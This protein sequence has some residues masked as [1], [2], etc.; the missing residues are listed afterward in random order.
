MNK[1][2]SIR[3][4]N[5]IRK[6]TANGHSESKLR[7][8]LTATDL[9]FLGI[10]AIVGAG[11]FILTGVA[12]A[13]KAGP[14][15]V[16]S[17]VLAGL[18][19]SFAAFAYAEL[20]STVGGAGSAYSYGYVTLGEF[21]AWIIGWDLILEYSVSVCAVAIGWS[22]YV[23]NVLEVLG[24]HLPAALIKGPGEG[25]ILNLPAIFIILFLCGIQALGVKHSARFNGIIVLM[26]L[27]AIGIFIAV[28][29][30]DFNLE[31]WSPFAPF[32]WSGI[33]GGAALVFFAYIGFDAVSTAA[34]ETIKPQR[35]LSIGILGSLMIC[36][37]LY[38][39][40]SG[41]L[42]G[43]TSYSLLNVKSPVSEAILHLGHAVA[44]G[45]IAVGAI[46]GLT[47]V[48][49]IFIYGFTRIFYAI[50]QDGLL[51]SFFS[52]IHPKT[53]VPHR[54]IGF[55]AL[56][57]S[58]IAGLFSI[59]EVAE[60]VNIG[61]LAAFVIVCVGVIVLR[62]RAPT[63]HRPFK[64]PLF[65]F[66]PIMGIILCGYLMLSLPAITW[67]RFV[68]WWIIGLL[69]YFTYGYRHSVLGQKS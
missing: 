7:R 47:S 45:F 34:E 52:S 19:C 36:T 63:L 55:S 48:I 29:I 69:I 59:G 35:D 66:S 13:T 53:Q 5:L 3:F 8:C 30:Q 24:I 37:V 15:I 65:P 54:I 12:A 25:G 39:V 16:I 1:Q 18:A 20:A 42:T 41:L 64:T 17:Y 49:F 6:K 50:T 31:N 68:I 9:I 32:G 51:P 60:L 11:I 40:V 27:T 4:K 2:F 57:M 58:P 46:A 44:A 14:A 23:N 22:G 62:Y 67:W 56:I 38:I 26:K 61:T 28:A 43:I 10:G 21:F 33:V